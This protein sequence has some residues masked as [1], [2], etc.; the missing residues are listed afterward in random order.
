LNEKTIY[1]TGE[2]KDALTYLVDKA[3]PVIGSAASSRGT[4]MYV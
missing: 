3:L 4:I 2:K 1:L